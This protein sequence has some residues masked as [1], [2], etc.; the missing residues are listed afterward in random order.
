MPR[1]LGLSWNERF[2]YDK[3][4]SHAIL[5]PSYIGTMIDALTNGFCEGFNGKVFYEIAAM[6]TA[7]QVTATASKTYILQ[8]C[9]QNFAV[10]TDATGGGAAA[11]VP[12]AVS[13][14]NR[15]I[16]DLYV[17]DVADTGM[18]FHQQDQLWITPAQSLVEV[19]MDFASIANADQ[20]NTISLGQFG[21]VSAKDANFLVVDSLGSALTNRPGADFVF[22]EFSN[23]RCRVVTLASSAATAITVGPWQQLSAGVPHII[24]LLIRNGKDIELIIDG[25]SRDASVKRTGAIGAAQLFGRVGHSASYVT[26]THSPIRFKLDSLLCSVPRQEG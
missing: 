22:V 21:V 1:P 24:K 11:G 23:S 3:Q 9:S 26:L 17:T 15:G 25:Q 2:A 12:D 6:G 20:L 19:V 18:G 16:L 4:T 10:V 13:G 8:G 5:G 7:T 14:T